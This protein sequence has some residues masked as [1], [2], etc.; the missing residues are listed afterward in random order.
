MKGAIKYRLFLTT[1][2]KGAMT[3]YKILPFESIISLKQLGNIFSRHFSASR[4]HPKSEASLEPIIQGRDESLC[5][6]DDRFNKESV[7]V[8]M[9]DA[10]KNYLLE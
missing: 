2:R 6:Y 9:T 4:Q 1:L 5:A 10:M 8:S 3:G 7:Q